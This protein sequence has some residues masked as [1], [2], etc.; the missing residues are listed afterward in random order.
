MKTL[1]SVLLILAL[2]AP[3]FGQTID[4]GMGAFSSERSPILIAIDAGLARL[5]LDKPYVMFNL[6]LAAKRADQSITVSRDDVVMV[7]Q[8]REYKMTPIRELRE[9][10][11]GQIRDVD[12]DRFLGKEGIIASWVRFY[13][14]PQKADFFPTMTLN[15]SVAAEEGSML[16][17]IGFDTKCYFN[18]PGFKKGDKLVIKVKDKK[19]P[20]LT[21]EVEVVL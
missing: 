6:F 12:F 5:E 4:L 3:V 13:Q 20:E 2:S 17:F 21:G 1:K 14:F 19:H 15:S 18:N 8:G 16:G 11:L 9:K 10:Y 7:Y